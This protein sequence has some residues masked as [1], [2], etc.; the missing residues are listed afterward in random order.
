[1]SF[2][3]TVDRIL[4][5]IGSL[6]RLKEFILEE[7]KELVNE[8]AVSEG[9]VDPPIRK[10]S[11]NSVPDNSSWGFGSSPEPP[12]SSLGEPSPSSS[13]PL[14]RPSL[15]TKVDQPAKSWTGMGSGL[16]DV[17]Q[18]VTTNVFGSTNPDRQPRSSPPIEPPTSTTLPGGS[19]LHLAKTQRR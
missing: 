1:M 5:D 9:T 18:S 2:S 14:S 4:S 16:V 11:R 19:C 12:G 13:S 6:E 10:T 8:P 3:T 17:G 7:R 15:Q